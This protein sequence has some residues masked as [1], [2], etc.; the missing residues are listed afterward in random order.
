MRRQV[1]TCDIKNI[2]HAA[3]MARIAEAHIQK[4][5]SYMAKMKEE[6]KKVRKEQNSSTK[7]GVKNLSRAIGDDQA[8]PLIVV[9]R[10]CDTKDGGEKGELT[11]NPRDTDAVV[12]RAWQAIHKGMSGCIEIAKEAFL[13][14][15]MKYVLKT[16]TSQVPGIPG[17][18]VYDSFKQTKQSA[19]A[20]DGRSPK[21][22]SLFSMGACEVIAVMLDHVEDGAPWPRSPMHAVFFF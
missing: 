14:K 17:Q 16:Q 3:K 12:K 15:Y 5:K 21:E 20:L 7:V 10:D 8:Q 22:M 4:A 13:N 19:G 2:I 1:Q 6:V 9:E 18:R 11:S